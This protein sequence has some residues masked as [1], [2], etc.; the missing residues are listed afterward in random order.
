MV[1]RSGRD[2]QR[3]DV[4]G[5][6]TPHD[7]RRRSTVLGGG[8][9]TQPDVHDRAVPGEVRRGRQQ[10]PGLGRA[11]RHRAVGPEH[12]PGHR[13]VVDADAARRVHRDDPRPPSP[14]PAAVGRGRGPLVVPVEHGGDAPHE[15]GRDASQ[16]AAG[17]DADEPVQHDVGTRDLH[18]H[19]V[20]D[21]GVEVVVRTVGPCHVVG[22]ADEHLDAAA[23]VAERREPA[24]VRVLAGQD[25]QHVD[26]PAREVRARVERV[27]AV[28][29]RPHEQDRPG[30]RPAP[31]PTAA[32]GQG[33]RPSSG[34]VAGHDGRERERGTLHER[35]A[36]GEQRLLGGAYVGDGPGFDHDLILPTARARRPPG[37][38][39]R[40]GEKPER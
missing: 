11:E 22:T 16:R 30:A 38:D 4:R 21:V 14:A 19:A 32:V 6:E 23:R 18:G 1:G 25:G 26:A 10:E 2:P 13:A 35:D 28:V 27:P 37:G 40:S 39:G 20:R 34:E 33:A 36:R 17:A 12:R 3:R 31:V 7:G 29:A 9:G 24:R 15:V 5:L 8:T